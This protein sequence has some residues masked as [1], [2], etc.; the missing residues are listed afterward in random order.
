MEKKPFYLLSL[1]AF[2]FAMS[3]L[4][5][6]VKKESVAL[7]PTY[8]IE[9]GQSA[10]ALNASSRQYNQLVSDAGACYSSWK[11]LVDK[12]NANNQANRISRRYD[13]QGYFNQFTWSTV[14]TG[15]TANF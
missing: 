3:S 9:V 15:F 5:V 11:T 10:M 13:L 12:A 1:T 2:L 6:S 4:N 7:Q 8:S 14:Y